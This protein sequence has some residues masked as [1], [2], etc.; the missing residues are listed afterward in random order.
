[1]SSCPEIGIVSK[2]FI[3]CCKIKKV[4]VR[5]DAVVVVVG[6]HSFSSWQLILWPSRLVSVYSDIMI[7][8]EKY[9]HSRLLACICVYISLYTGDGQI[10]LQKI[11][12][13]RAS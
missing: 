12:K 7:K 10:Y 11:I 13:L 5:V 1:M 6:I 2:M 9:N 4:C 3:L 8:I